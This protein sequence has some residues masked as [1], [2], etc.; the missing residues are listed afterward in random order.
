MLWTSI[1]PTLGVIGACLPTL[2]PFFS[3]I[4]PESVIRSIRSQIS[5]HS[6]RSPR[7]S[8]KGSP[9]GS[10]NTTSRTENSSESNER[11]VH[12][13]R[14][15]GSDTVDN[16]ITTMELEDRNRLEKTWTRRGNGVHLDQ[17]IHQRTDDM[18]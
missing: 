16:H 8:P 13:E 5:L 2:R 12:V 3:G 1:E 18:V 17:D 6:L 15:E 10:R 11:F 9:K 7:A 14:A 4:S